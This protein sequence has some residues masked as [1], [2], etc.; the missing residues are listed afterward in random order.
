MAQFDVH[1]LDDGLR[2]V[3]LQT[4]LIGLDVTRLVA[5]LRGPDR[6]RGLPGPDARGSLRDER[7]ALKRVVDILIDGV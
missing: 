5:S 6:Q 3:D 7:D 4:D 2:V 1:R